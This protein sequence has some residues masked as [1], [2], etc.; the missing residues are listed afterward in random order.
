MAAQEDGR[1][2][3]WLRAL[4]L[5]PARLSYS[6]PFRPMRYPEVPGAHR[7]VLMRR[8]VP[9]N[10]DAVAWLRLLRLRTGA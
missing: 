3:S 10:A 9:S 1:S 4:H 5:C 2:P 8:L 7:E 6:L